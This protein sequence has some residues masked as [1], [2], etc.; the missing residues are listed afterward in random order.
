[1]EKS[2]VCIPS[3]SFVQLP[4]AMPYPLSSMLCMHVVDSP[5]DRARMQCHSVFLCLLTAE[6]NLIRLSTCRG[7]KHHDKDESCDSYE[8]MTYTDNTHRKPDFQ[9]MQPGLHQGPRSFRHW[10]GSSVVRA[11]FFMS[12]CSTLQ[13]HRA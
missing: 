10:R 11:H 13:W 1:M 2:C 12:V 5:L 9:G 3:T 4:L 8:H 6:L 7:T